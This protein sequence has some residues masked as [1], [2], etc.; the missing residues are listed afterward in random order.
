M[1]YL[2]WKQWHFELSI[3]QEIQK[4]NFDAYFFNDMGKN[5]SKIA[6]WKIFKTLKLLCL[7]EQKQLIKTNY[8]FV[9]IKAIT[10]DYVFFLFVFYY[11]ITF[12]HVYFL[13]AI[14]C[15][16]LV[17]FTCSKMLNLFW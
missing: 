10:F 6:S 14:T 4:G 8:N 9:C 1:V 17:Y 11:L 13:S 7:P 15:S 3:R 2:Q 5:R 12:L 16:H